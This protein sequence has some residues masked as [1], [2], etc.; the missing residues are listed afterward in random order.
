MHI[1]NTVEASASYAEPTINFVL[2]LA[3]AQISSEEEED[4]YDIVP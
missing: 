1:I 3:T 2:I 4:N